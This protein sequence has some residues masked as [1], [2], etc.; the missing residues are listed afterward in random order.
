MATSVEYQTIHENREILKKAMEDDIL[1]ISDHL[2]KVNMI[3]PENH[4]ALKSNAQTNHEKVELL[5]TLFE[6]RIQL[7]PAADLAKF[8]GILKIKRVYYGKAIQVLQVALR[9][10]SPPAASQLLQLTEHIKHLEERMKELELKHGNQQSSTGNSCWVR[11]III[12]VWVL[13]GIILILVTFLPKDMA[14]PTMILASISTFFVWLFKSGN[15]NITLLM[16]Y[17]YCTAYFQNNYQPRGAN[18]RT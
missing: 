11:F 17:V 9:D 15:I 5:M 2:M 1:F 6:N 13:I 14:T 8:V 4:T 12:V 18:T 10:K 16:L 3:T 7:D